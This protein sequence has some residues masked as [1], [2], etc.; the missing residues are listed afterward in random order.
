M[1]RCSR[2]G[3]VA[4]PPRGR[5][6]TGWQQGRI[7]GRAVV[8]FPVRVRVF[9]RQAARAWRRARAS[10]SS[11]SSTRVNVA[12]SGTPAASANCAASN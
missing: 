6:R 7:P 3:G 9:C 11:A 5:T 2:C 4:A 8:E 1:L 12:G 10:G